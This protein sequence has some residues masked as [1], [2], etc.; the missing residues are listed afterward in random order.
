MIDKAVID[1][2]VQ[3]NLCKRCAKPG[4]W[5]IDC[6]NSVNTGIPRAERDRNR[7]N[8]RGHGRSSGS[9]NGSRPAMGQTGYGNG[10]YVSAIG[11]GEAAAPTIPDVA[12]APAAAP[13]PPAVDHNGNSIL[14]SARIVHGPRRSRCAALVDSGCSALAF[15]DR[16]FATRC[17]LPLLKLPKPKALYLADGVPKDLITH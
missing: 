6:R 5:A 2:R 10:A 13:A 12:A 1:Y 3:N 4:H 7:R 8:N 14:L 9:G 16:S 15:I 17:A 11:T